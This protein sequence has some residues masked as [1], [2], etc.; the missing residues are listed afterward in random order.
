MEMENRMEMEMEYIPE[1]IHNEESFLK[2]KTIF[3]FDKFF[4]LKC[5]EYFL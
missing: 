2:L 3:L 1:Y 4:F 5:K